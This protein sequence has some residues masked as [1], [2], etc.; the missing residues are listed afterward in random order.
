MSAPKKYTAENL[1]GKS[2]E[3]LVKIVLDKQA[4]LDLTVKI[5]EELD[6]KVAEL[7]K[8]VPPVVEKAKSDIS[9]ETFEF[10]KEKFGFKK[11]RIYH[12]DNLITAAEVLANKE[13]QADL[14]KIGS[15]M[16]YKIEKD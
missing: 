16:L 14:V 11:A 5:N 4:E 8:A 13:L 2:P 3:E 9:D 7:S 15:G 10:K 12:K 1:A 6:G